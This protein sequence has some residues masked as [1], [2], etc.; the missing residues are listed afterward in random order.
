MRSVLASA[1]VVWLLCSG[2]AA[3]A[4]KP[5]I[6]ILGLEVIPGASG[7]VDPTVT[8]VARDLTI[9]LRQ[10]VQSDASPYALAQNSTKEL[11]D[12]KLLNSCDNEAAACMALIGIGLSADFLLYGHIEKRGEHYRIS[13]RLLDVKAKTF[14]TTGEDIPVGTSVTT[15][16]K[17]LYGRLFGERNAAAAAGVLVIKA[18]TRGGD[19]VDGGQVFVDDVARGTIARGKLTVNVMSEERHA[20]AIEAPGYARFEQSVLVRSGQPTTLDASLEAQ[21]STSSPAHHAAAWK[22]SLG[23]GIALAI[24]GGGFAYYSNDQMVNHNKVTYA[25][26]TDPATGM[27]YAKVQAPD[28]S[29]CGQS[30]DQIR[31]NKGAEVTN[32][33]AFTRACTW[34][35]RIYIGYVVGGVGVLGAVVS[36]IMLT[37]DVHTA[38]SSPTGTRTKKPGIAIAPLLRPDAAGASLSLHW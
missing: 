15:M 7:T 28:A 3:W 18:R 17:R 35:T 37:R 13:V 2:S 6:A 22:W 29:D 11:T 8:Q 10:R 23:G 9:D 16:S 5:K 27:Q 26:A 33:D 38:E 31:I 4:A 24:A 14:D 32:Q 1:C 21:A 30:F 25:P 20:V 34:K 12:E 36:L 19:A